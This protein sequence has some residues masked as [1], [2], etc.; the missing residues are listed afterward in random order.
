MSYVDS[1]IFQQVTTDLASR[2]AGMEARL[3]ELFGVVENRFREE[4][5][6]IME[7]K[8]KS[9]ANSGIAERLQMDITQIKSEMEGMKIEVPQ[10]LADILTESKE[11]ITGQ[12][13]TMETAFQ[14]AKDAYQRLNVQTS[15]IKVEVT[16]LGT[17]AAS[18]GGGGF[19]KKKIIDLKPFKIEKLDGDKETK[20]FLEEWRDDV[21]DFM[22]GH[23]TGLK[24]VMQKAARWKTEIDEE[25]IDLLL[26]ELGTN[27]QSLQWTI[28]EIDDEPVTFLKKHLM[29]MARKAFIAA[30][31]GFLDGYRRMITEI[32]P[33]NARTKGIMMDAITG[34]LSKGRASNAKQLK[35]RLLDLEIMVTKYFKRLNE[36]PEQSLLASVLSNMLDEKT[37]ETFT[38]DAVLG[39]FKAMKERISATATESDLGRDAMNIG[40]IEVEAQPQA[41]KVEVATSP[42]TLAEWPVS[43]RNGSIQY[44]Y[45]RQ[46]VRRCSCES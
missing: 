22:N 9:E 11:N 3:N 4:A 33:V 45:R 16:R 30:K 37:R 5:Q 27:R 20:N 29:G 19:G 38:N 32:D 17:N 10:R 46:A 23:H 40:A 25:Q 26:S 28:E 6:N 18:G 24:A 2:L 36:K 44:E 41:L 34:M 13:R 14:E 8:L 31:G 7:T 15:S 35:A 42:E 12:V 21:E 43:T 1:Q 39:N